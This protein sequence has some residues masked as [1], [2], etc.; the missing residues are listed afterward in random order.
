[1]VPAKATRSLDGSAAHI[2]L[3]GATLGGR[4]ATYAQL[5]TR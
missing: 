1:V 2:D 4:S 3:V 5:D